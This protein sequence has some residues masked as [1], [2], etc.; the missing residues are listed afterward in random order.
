MNY[1]KLKPVAKHVWLHDLLYALLDYFNP[2]D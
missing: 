1:N 2:N